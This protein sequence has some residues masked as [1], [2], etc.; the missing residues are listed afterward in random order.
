[1]SLGN[2]LA[3]ADATVALD[4]SK[5][6]GSY[7]GPG[8]T[9]KRE[10]TVTLYSA[11]KGAGIVFFLTDAQNP[12][13]AVAVPARASMV[14]NTMRNVVLGVDKVRLCIVEHFLCA[15]TLWGIDDLYVSVDGPEMPLHDGS[16]DFWIN[17]FK[18]SGIA[19]QEVV[20][21]IALPEA[22]TVAK[23]D[24]ALMAVPADKFSVTYLM[25]WKHPLIGQKWQSWD[26]SIDAKEIFEARTFGMLKDHILLGLDKDVVSMTDDGFTMPLRYPDEPVRHKLLDL[27]G[28]LALIGINPMRI[29]ACFISI[30]GGHEM[31]VDIAR[32]LVSLLGTY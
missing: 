18:E 25:D 31:D 8:L 29:K 27:I 9:S 11:P 24:R 4:P 6:L 21:D 16:A 2:T 5:K 26:P 22:V 3:I 19:K 32:K 12:A 10:I 17:L 20:C 1:M 14:V 28:D 23:G 13:K 15:T 30:K 7:T